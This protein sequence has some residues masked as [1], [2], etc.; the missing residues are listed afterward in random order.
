MADIVPHA[1]REPHVVMQALGH[2]DGLAVRRMN[3]VLRDGA[4]EGDASD[5]IPERLR[6]VQGASG[7][8][9]G[10]SPQSDLVP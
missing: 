6:E 1:L 10:K 5:L 2:G 8:N 4:G 7:R 3:R 9:R